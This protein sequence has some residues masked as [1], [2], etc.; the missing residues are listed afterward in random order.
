M[1]SAM[2]QL[3]S[4]AALPDY[5]NLPLWRS[6][7]KSGEIA[8]HQLQQIW[9]TAQTLHCSVIEALETVTKRPLSWEKRQFYRQREQWELQIRYGVAYFDPA[10]QPVDRAWIRGC[11]QSM[12]PLSLCDHYHLIPLQMDPKDGALLWVGMLNPDNT[13]AI[14]YLRYGL[15]QQRLE[16]LQVR[17]WVMSMDDYYTLLHESL[18][19][20]VI[21]TSVCSPVPPSETITPIMPPIAPAL[22]ANSPEAIDLSGLPI[23]QENTPSEVDL[24]RE[25][26]LSSAHPIVSLVN[27]IL[28]KALQEGVSDIHF[29]PQETALQIRFRKDGLLQL[30]CP[31]LPRSSIPVI[32]SRLKILAN[33]DIAD[34]RVPQ[35]GQIRLKFQAQRVVLRVST[36]PTYYGEKVVL[37]VL[38]SSSSDLKLESFLTDL[39][40]L[41][42]FRGMISRPYGLILVT[43]PTGSGKSTTLYGAIAEKNTP[44]IN[45]STVE[46]PVEYLLPGISQVQV[47]REKGMDFPQVLRALLRQDPDVILVGEIRDRE[48]AKVA[49]EASLTGH[50]VLS[51]L[52]T[53]DAAGTIVRLQE[54][55]IDPFRVSSCLIGVLAQRLVRQVCPHCRLPYTPTEQDWRSVRWMQPKVPQPPLYRAQ[56]VSA[57]ENSSPEI[58]P[59]CKGMGY[60]GRMGVYELLNVD[61][62]IKDLIIG[63]ASADELRDAAR[64]GGMKTLTDY[65]LQLVVDGKT[66]LAEV[67]RVLLSSLAPE[68]ETP[69]PSRSLPSPALPKYPEDYNYE[70]P[71]GEQ[72]HFVTTLLAVT[73]Y[74]MNHPNL[75]I[76]S[77]L[78]WS[79]QLL[80]ILQF[81]KN[82]PP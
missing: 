82:L 71:S 65:G 21:P 15:H 9:Q 53:N 14:D 75:A 23:P 25:L 52:H 64:L 38:K 20:S 27:A 1:G 77:R 43:G 16:G 36:L 70:Q 8:P 79:N 80:Q 57:L 78:R 24:E 60:K 30:S 49:V 45:I 4:G 10:L 76:E 58:C 26:R 54:L 44:Q 73:Q 62:T 35:D 2:G 31:P 81:L 33:L 48:T 3:H 7:L 55:G 13:E 68:D 67:E 12:V 46:D 66:T 39:P 59:H 41:S 74:L 37:R 32:T 40:I 63:G 47:I 50:L 28:F 51:T 34:R 11:L 5:L 22:E 29:E 6:L 18:D 69:S 17:R 72:Q 61:R 42:Q 56:V 19:P